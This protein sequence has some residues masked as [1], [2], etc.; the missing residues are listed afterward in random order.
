MA[1]LTGWG[2]GSWNSSTWGDPDVLVL[3]G[4]A[5]TSALGTVTTLG[6]VNVAPTGIAANSALG[7]IITG[8]SV[9][10]A[11]TGVS[12][13]GVIGTTNVWGLIDTEQT[14]N[15]EEIAA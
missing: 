13:T 6:D 5:A 1:N 12:G 11:I 2:R 9:T 3:T 7:D 8:I 15:W 14:P 10:F 4:V